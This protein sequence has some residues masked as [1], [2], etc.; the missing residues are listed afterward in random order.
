[1]KN[2]LIAGLLGAGAAGGGV[3]Y[4]ARNNPAVGKNIADFLNP[5]PEE[6]PGMLDQAGSAIGE[7]LQKIDPTTGSLRDNMPKAVTAMALLGLLGYG[8]Y[9]LGQ[10]NKQREFERAAGLR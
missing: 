1:M 9:K 10:G 7:G 5:Q 2:S 3:T 8:G 4:A 6:D